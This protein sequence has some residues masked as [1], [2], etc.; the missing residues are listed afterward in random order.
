MTGE[1]P[2]MELNRL[3][4]APKDLVFAAWT[5]PTHLQ[6]WFVPNGFKVVL[7]EVD[8][9]VGGS[10]KV[11]WEDKKGTRYPNIGVYTVIAPTDRLCYVDS[12]DDERDNNP[13]TEVEILFADE[14]GK[15]RMTSISTF[16]SKEKLQ[17]LLGMGLEQG[18][19]AFLDGLAEYAA[20]QAKRR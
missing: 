19:N 4:D 9:R 11:H 3:I 18:W 13:R 15:T 1:K 2:I 5:D 16:E 17:E 8:L 12:F 20:A 6:A 14:D 10:F 7:C